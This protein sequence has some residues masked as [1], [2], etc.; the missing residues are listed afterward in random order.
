MM[1]SYLRCGG[2]EVE[3]SDEI[4]RP[5]PGIDLASQ[6][7]E[8]FLISTALAQQH[9]EDVTDTSRATS[10]FARPA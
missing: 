8:P 2:V 6:G 9:F 3:G 4:F 10:L 5:R 1:V 7:R